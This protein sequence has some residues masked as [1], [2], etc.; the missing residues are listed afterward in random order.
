MDSASDD[1]A[2]ALAEALVLLDEVKAGR[3]AGVLRI[4]RPQPTAAFGGRDR[5]LPGFSQAVDA[6]RDHGFTP[7][8]RS[9]GGRVAVYHPGSLVI[10]H[11]E[12]ADDLLSGTQQR[13]SSFGEFYTQVLRGIGVDARLGEIPGEYCPGEHSVN[14]AGRI[15][16]IGTA[17]RVTSRGWLFSSSIIITDPDPIRAVLIDIESALGVTWDPATGGAISEIHPEITV[18]QA[19]EAFTNAFA[20]RCRL[21]PGK[22]TAD[23][24]RAASQQR[25]RHVL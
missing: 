23:E 18:D 25:D 5:F 21:I 6:A 15:K 20:E 8:L 22:L 3:R 16:A 1:P 9:L 19:T 14:V 17:Q 13:F 4:Y 12:P 7:V 24:A 10:D 11:L 2:T